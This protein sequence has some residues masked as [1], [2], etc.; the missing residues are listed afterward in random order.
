MTVSHNVCGSYM[1]WY[2]FYQIHSLE[3]FA[4]CLFSLFK[5]QFSVFKQHY[6]YF[7]ILFYLHIFPKNTNNITR[8][9]LPNGP[10]D[11]YSIKK[12]PINIYIYTH[13]YDWFNIKKRIYKFIFYFFHF[14]NNT[15]ICKVYTTFF[16]SFFQC[17]YT[18]E[19]S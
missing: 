16:F 19:S 8:N 7:Y 1:L 17:H 9:F 2:M 6:T 18:K 14:K 3:L 10:L 11:T 15:S 4:I 13:T 12:L 5:Q